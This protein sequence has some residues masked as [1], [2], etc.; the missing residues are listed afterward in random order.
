MAGEGRRNV[1][2][3]KERLRDYASSPDRK[4]AKGKRPGAMITDVSL[5][6]VLFVSNR[7][8][9]IIR[10]PQPTCI[11]RTWLGEAMAAPSGRNKAMAERPGE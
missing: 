9:F 1:G 4:E 10:L 8:V 5:S 3:R 6:W 2:N 7:A 11:H